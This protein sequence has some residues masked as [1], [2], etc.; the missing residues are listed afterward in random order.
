MLHQPD[1]SHNSNDGPCSL[2]N[3]SMAKLVSLDTIVL[4][5]TTGS[6]S[7]VT[8]YKV[9]QLSV[10]PGHQVLFV[11]RSN[12]HVL[13]SKSALV[14]N[15]HFFTIDK[16]DPEFTSPAAN[17]CTVFGTCGLFGCSGGAG[18]G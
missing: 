3:E 11:S 13:F 16:W 15:G 9:A 4:N 14:V 6:M 18:C 10:I 5:V 17:G 2:V 12:D 1:G 7:L 8:N